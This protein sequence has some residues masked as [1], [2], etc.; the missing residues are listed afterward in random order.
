MT[1]LPVLGASGNIYK[2]LLKQ[3]RKRLGFSRSQ[4]GFVCLERP[5]PIIAFL[6][7]MKSGQK[8]MPGCATRSN[9]NTR[10]VEARRSMFGVFILVS[11]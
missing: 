5:V 1:L 4:I 2:L 8:S 9:L 10:E 11:P 6:F 7:R 3:V